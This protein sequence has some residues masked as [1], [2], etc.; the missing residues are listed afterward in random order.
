M[1]A[2]PIQMIIGHVED[3]DYAPGTKIICGDEGK[4][5]FLHPPHEALNA[6]N[7]IEILERRM[8]ELAGAPK[9]AMG[10]RTPGEKTKFEVQVLDNAS[11]RIFLNK[12]I[13][14]QKTFFEKVLNYA[15]GMSRQHMSGEDVTRTLDSEIDAVIFSTVTRDDIS[16]N[17]V[18]RP[19]GAESFAEKANNLQNLMQI[20][21]SQI[22][23]DATVMNHWSGKNLAKAIEELADLKKFNLYAENVRILEQQE[24]LQL[25]NAAGEQTDIQAVT[26]AGILPGDP[27]SGPIE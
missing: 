14:F 5:E 8:E 2:Y 17:G 3:Y 26:P 22:A 23:Q 10:M 16:A 6:D 21:G 12:I 11:Q 20:L 13:H 4:V 27:A 19:R 7:Q 18:L 1:I 25:Q 15:L 24:S 9:E